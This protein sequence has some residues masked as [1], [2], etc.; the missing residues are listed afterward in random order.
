MVVVETNRFLFVLGEDGDSIRNKGK[1]II[2]RYYRKAYISCKVTNDSIKMLF[3]GLF[4][5]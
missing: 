3:S 1:I 5:L 4:K 2:H